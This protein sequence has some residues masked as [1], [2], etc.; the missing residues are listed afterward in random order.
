VAISGDFEYPC[1]ATSWNPGD[2]VGGYCADTN[3]APASQQVAQVTAWDEAI[4]VAKVPYNALG[5]SMTSII[6]S[7]RPNYLKDAVVS[8][9]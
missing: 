4:G 3:T 1:A 9:Y 7:I 2:L 8:G 6:V 5:T